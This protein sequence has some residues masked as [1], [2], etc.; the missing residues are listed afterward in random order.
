MSSY[1][2]VFKYIIVGAMG[3][4][5]SSLLTRF[6]EDKF[7]PEISHT[8]GVEFATKIIEIVKERVKLQVWDTAGQERFRAV[9]RSYYRGTST[10][11]LVYDISRYLFFF[12]FIFF[13]LLL[14][15]LILY[16]LFFHFFI[17]YGFLFIIFLYSFFFNFFF[18]NFF[19][20][21][22]RFFFIHFLFLSLYLFIYIII[23]GIKG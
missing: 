9:T 19:L 16:F 14:I 3:V 13:F 2:Y 21:N 20:F 22:F 17:F 11:F 18:F 8:I 1:N 4:G 7:Y 23:F 12:I 5:K 15:I 10:V 6:I